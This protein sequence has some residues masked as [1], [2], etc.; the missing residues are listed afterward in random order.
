MELGENFISLETDNFLLKVMD[1]VE[2]KLS[3]EEIIRFV[4]QIKGLITWEGFF[5]VE[6][7]HPYIN[8]GFNKVK[9]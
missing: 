1:G 6:E 9:L 4:V 2:L 7:M 5:Q 3:K 8:M